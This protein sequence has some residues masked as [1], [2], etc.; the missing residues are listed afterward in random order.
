MVFGLDA[1]PDGAEAVAGGAEVGGEGGGDVAPDARGELA[2]FAVGCYA[3][4]EGAVG[5]CGEEGEGAERWGVD[6]IDGD[7][8]AFAVG[9]DV[10]AWGGRLVFGILGGGRGGR[11]QRISWGEGDEDGVDVVV[12]FWPSQGRYI[13]VMVGL[14]Q[15]LHLL[16]VDALLER[17]VHFMLP[18]IQVE[19]DDG[20]SADFE[21][22]RAPRGGER[23]GA[24]YEVDV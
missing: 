20:R 13:I 19:D 1:L 17:G 5:V 12:Q 3:D 4:L 8:V 10:E 14:R 24:D 15:P 18:V 7:A 23:I 11:T 21:G 9:G 6:D 22:F 16:V 2:A